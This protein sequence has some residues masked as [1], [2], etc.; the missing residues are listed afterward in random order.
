MEAKFA[1]TQLNGQ[2]VKVTGSIIYNFV[3]P[4]DR[5]GNSIRTLNGGVLNGK[6]TSL[7]SPAYPPA[8]QA[9]GA[10]GTVIVQVTID[11]QGNV[12]SAGAI[13][14]HPLLRGAATEA[15]AKSTF[16]PTRL[17]ALVRR[18]LIISAK[19]SLG[20]PACSACRCCRSMTLLGS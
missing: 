7:P 17:S 13:S 6:A 5:D 1:P 12:V 18:D 10:G 2:P 14:G 15:A 9:I 8:A 4:H 3:A 20:A 16:L 11:E 19:R